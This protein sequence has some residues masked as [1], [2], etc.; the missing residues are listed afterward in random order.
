MVQFFLFSVFDFPFNEGGFSRFLE[1]LQQGTQGS[2]LRGQGEMLK[3]QSSELKDQGALE[4]KP[5]VLRVHGGHSWA[6]L[7][8]R[9]EE[10]A[11]GVL[12][13]AEGAP[14]RSAEGAPSM[15]T[16]AEGANARRS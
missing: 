4:H 1:F 14:L 11:E 16:S 12:L 15:A 3:T 6:P 2:G 5:L 10:N 8:D 9:D 7:T 13:R